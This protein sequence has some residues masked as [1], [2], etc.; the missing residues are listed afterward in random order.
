MYFNTSSLIIIID[1]RN[2]FEQTF[3]DNSN[4]QSSLHITRLAKL[5]LDVLAKSHSLETPST[6]LQM[7]NNYHRYPNRKKS[8][9]ESP[10]RQLIRSRNSR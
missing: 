1:S 10:N 9:L 6:I 5:T 2:Y 7:H 8:I 3:L 4:K